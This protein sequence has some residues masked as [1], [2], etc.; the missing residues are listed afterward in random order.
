MRHV[1]PRL[2][3]VI[4]AACMTVSILQPFQAAGQPAGTPPAQVDQPDF[5]LANVTDPGDNN[6]VLQLNPGQSRELVIGVINAGESPI[7]LRTYAANVIS[8]INGGFGAGTEKDE[9]QGPT[10]WISYPAATM[11][12]Q[13]KQMEKRPFTVSVPKGTAPGQYIAALIVQTNESVPIP[14]TTA[15]RQIIRKAMKVTITVPGPVT[16]GFKLGA[17]TFVTEPSSRTLNIPITNTG[18]IL[19]EPAGTFNVTTPDD[20]TVMTGPITMGVVYGGMSTGI[21]FSLAPQFQPG[22][23]LISLDLKDAR[24]GAAA[25]IKNAKAT[26]APPPAPAMTETEQVPPFVVDAVSI[27]PQ[28]SPVQYAEVTATLTNNQ[29]LIPAADVT[30]I[31]KRD[32]EKIE[33]YPL[34]R[35]QALPQGQTKIAQRY[36]P[37]DGWKAGKWTF[38]V[39]VSAVGLGTGTRTTLAT[40]D[41]PGAITVP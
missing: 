8:V 10:R 15:F 30:L 9:P 28:G 18:N 35:N 29:Q 3:T 24:T 20:K 39:V 6:V 38:Q 12:L 1:S 36:I 7:T 5:G 21:Q 19:V 2:L 16:P 22:D 13:S 17:P 4:V 40:V 41:V 31:V 33:Q 23:Y 14:G 25:S 27:T 34:A 32:G 37:K 26:L 11:T